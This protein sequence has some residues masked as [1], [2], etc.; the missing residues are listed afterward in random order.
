MSIIRKGIVKTLSVMMAMVAILV[1]TNDNTVDAAWDLVTE[2]ANA[3]SGDTVT[4]SEDVDESSV[5]VPE[6]VILVIPEGI[7]LSVWTD[8]ENNGLLVINGTLVLPGLDYNDETDEEIPAYDID[9]LIDCTGTGKVIIDDIEYTYMADTG[10]FGC[11]HTTHEH[12]G[13]CSNSGEYMEHTYDEAGKC[14]CGLEAGARVVYNGATSY[15]DHVLLAMMAADD[16]LSENSDSDIII[17]ADG[18]KVFW[19]EHC[20]SYNVVLNGSIYMPGDGFLEISEDGILTITESGILEGDVCNITNKGTIVIPE[21]D[22]IP[23]INGEMGSCV[24]VGDVRYAYTEGGTY[25]VC[26]HISY[27]EGKCSGC[28]LVCKHESFTIGTDVE[29]DVCDI[30]LDLSIEVSECI[31]TGEKINP[32]IKVVAGDVTLV[33]GTDYTVAWPADMVNAG[34]KTVTITG[35]GKYSGATTK[36]FSIEKENI[37]EDD[38]NDNNNEDNGNSN[39]NVAGGDGENTTPDTGDVSNIVTIVAFMM[40]SGAVVMA[41][42]CKRITLSE[43]N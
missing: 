10:K 20:I 25:E 21:G 16:I 17:Y 43:S 12:S 3:N 6:G 15:Y 5:L 18:Q 34:D 41:T 31:Y 39:N 26:D 28:R 2:L 35:I 23:D 27:T 42:S 7:T 22:D 29:C 38:R 32:T 40:V 13:E 8:F 24:V 14:T 33:E 19:G 4:L 36:T 9:N 37:N 1:I 11:P 30:S